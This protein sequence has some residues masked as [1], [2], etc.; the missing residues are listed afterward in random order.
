MVGSRVTVGDVDFPLY[1]YN[2]A[3]LYKVL[4]TLVRAAVEVSWKEPSPTVTRMNRTLDV[5][6]FVDGIKL[7][8]VADKT[9]TFE[10]IHW[11]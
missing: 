2:C 8:D 1:P 3:G 4:Y 5:G 6:T 11:K 9:D 7:S 10:H